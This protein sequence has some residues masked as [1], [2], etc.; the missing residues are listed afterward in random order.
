M[1]RLSLIFLLITL[2]AADDFAQKRTSPSFTRI[3]P[4]KGKAAEIGQTAIV[5][6]EVLNVLRVKPS[7]TAEIIHRV[8]RGR[9]VQITGVAEADGVK[10]YKVV[11]PPNSFGWI[12]A[13]A[14][15][16][17]FRPTDE[18]RFADMVRA[19]EG[20]DQIEIGTEF[21][22]MYPDSKLRPVILLL[23]GDAVEQLAL[24]LSKNAN[25]QLKSSWIAASA[26]P[27]QSYY[28]NFV[29]LDRYKKL[30]VGF[31]FNPT[32][33][34][35]HYDGAK[36]AEIVKVYGSSNEAAEA[37]KRLDSLNVKMGRVA[38]AAK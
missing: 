35:Y 32:T 10:F 36:W 5:M 16:G 23:F 4:S 6:D 8:S 31:L 34:A 37:K 15:V 11:S 29:Q 3:A 1:R 13:D 22:K 38:A 28:L 7:L 2:A 12:Q 33:R 30:G 18:K 26:A 14:V 19:S 21:F 20:F 24:T 9:K 17:R 27:M 25:R